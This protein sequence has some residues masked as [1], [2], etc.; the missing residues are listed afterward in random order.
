LKPP[1]KDS[2]I[3]W[4]GEMVTLEARNGEWWLG[5]GKGIYRFAPQEFKHLRS[6]KPIAIYDVKKGLTANQVF[7]LFEDSHGDI[8]VSAILP[9]GL[10]R[11]DRATE[12]LHDLTTSAGLPSGR[13]DLARC[14]GE[15]R[16]G[17]VWVGFSS[18]LARYKDGNFTVFR[19]EDGLPAG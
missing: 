5:T 10:G 3:G 9:N 11:W 7:R 6:A 4:V 18:A 12:T 1:I 8:W 17:N 16:Y 15:D 19:Q 14:F 2:D 13:D